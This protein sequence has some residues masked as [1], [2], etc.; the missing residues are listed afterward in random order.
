ML[1]QANEIISWLNKYNCFKWFRNS[2][3]CKIS[4]GFW[5]ESN[6]T[7]EIIYYILY[8]IFCLYSKNKEILQGFSFVGP[9]VEFCFKYKIEHGYQSWQCHLIGWGLKLY[10]FQ[11]Q[12]SGLKVNFSDNN[13][14][15]VLHIMFHFCS[16]P[17]SKM[18]AT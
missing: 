8:E 1:R 7:N 13:P 12:V 16:D 18:A 5:L 15:M 2:N 10:C 17:K 3:A 14:G 11:K 4:E 6:P 9:Q